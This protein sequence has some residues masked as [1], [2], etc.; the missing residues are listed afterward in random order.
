MDGGGGSEGAGGSGSVE[1]V[2]Q[3]GRCEVMEGFESMEEDFEINTEF[4]R[5]PVELL[6]DRGDVME[7]GGSGDDAGGSV[8]DQLELME[9]FLR[10]TKEEGVAVV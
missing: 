3:I 2:G 10:E 4:N 9:G 8:L 1:E 5:E 6:Q 7:G